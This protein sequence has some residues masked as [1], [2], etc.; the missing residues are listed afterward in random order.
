MIWNGG[1]HMNVSMILI[2]MSYQAIIGWKQEKIQ[3][4]Y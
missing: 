1:T 2:V 4:I 3:N